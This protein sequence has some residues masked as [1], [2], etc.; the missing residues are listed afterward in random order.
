[1]HSK[2]HRDFSVYNPSS[3]TLVNPRVVGQGTTTMFMHSVYMSSTEPNQ[4]FLA[5]AEISDIGLRFYDY[6]RD[7]TNETFQTKSDESIYLSVMCL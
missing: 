6:L 5:H 3:K 7:L 4:H 2:D 1:M